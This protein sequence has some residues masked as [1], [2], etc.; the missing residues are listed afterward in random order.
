MLDE[1]GNAVLYLLKNGKLEIKDVLQSDIPYSIRRS[2]IINYT[3][4]LKN[5]EIQE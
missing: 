2:V 1:I 4:Y 5:G 3:N